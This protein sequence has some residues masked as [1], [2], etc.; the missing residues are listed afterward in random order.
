MPPH[1]RHPRRWPRRRRSSG[2]GAFAQARAQ[3]VDLTVGLVDP[4][5]RDGENGLER[6]AACRPPATP[7]PACRDR[8]WRGRPCAALR[9]R[10]AASARRPPETHPVARI[11]LQQRDAQRARFHVVGGEREIQRGLGQGLEAAILAAQRPH[12][13]I[14]ELLLPP[15][16]RDPI[17]TRANLFS[18]SARSL[19]A[20]PAACRKRRTGL[21]E[22]ACLAFSTNARGSGCG[23]QVSAAPALKAP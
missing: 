12:P 4:Q 7:F 22:L 6:V 3:F 1:R 8:R 10:R 18:F 2:A 11:G 5:R 21:R 9:C 20:H 14:F 23:S 16:A 17:R 15:Q 13:R 19:N